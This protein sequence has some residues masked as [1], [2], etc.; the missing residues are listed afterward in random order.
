MSAQVHTIRSGAKLSEAH[1]LMREHRIRH[2]PVLERGSLVGLVSD[3]DLHLVETLGVGSPEEITVEEA[4]SQDV[5]VAGPGE[6]IP[7]VARRMAERKAGSAVIVRNDHV[8]GI[9]TTV[10]ALRLLAN[11]VHPEPKRAATRQ[12]KG[13]RATGHRD[14]G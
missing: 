12:P 13:A 14:R 4:M 6:A 7:D 10:D 5:L 3:R 8:I 9:F 1:A 11:H 2:L